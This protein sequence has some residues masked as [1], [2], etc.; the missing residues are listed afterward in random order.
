M[1]A[2][3]IVGTLL[4][5]QRVASNA[6]PYVTFTPPTTGPDAILPGD[7]MVVFLASQASTATSPNIVNAAWTAITPRTTNA[8]SFAYAAM[9]KVRVAGETSYGFS[10]SGSA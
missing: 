7:I 9:A 6:N 4:S 10:G 5:S 2:P 1:A 8:N 3:Y